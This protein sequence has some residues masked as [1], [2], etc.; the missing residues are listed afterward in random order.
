M[1]ISDWCSVVCSSDLQ[2]VPPADPYAHLLVGRSG[3]LTGTIKFP[4]PIDPTV[5]AGDLT[6]TVD[7]NR[8]P[9]PGRTTVFTRR[10]G[11]HTR[12]PAGVVEYVFTAGGGAADANRSLTPVERREGSGPIPPASVV[13]RTS[14]RLN[15]SH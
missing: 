6:L 1:C 12:T 7:V 13:D 9:Q 4:I 2:P 15:S 11:D 3:S 8:Q 10:Y 14:T 5:T